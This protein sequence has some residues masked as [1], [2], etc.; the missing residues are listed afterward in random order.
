MQPPYT[1]GMHVVISYKSGIDFD[2]D[3]NIFIYMFLS[4]DEDEVIHPLG[5]QCKFVFIYLIYL[6]V[7]PLTYDKN[8]SIFQVLQSA[9]SD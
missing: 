7:V 9:F 2:F 8:S 1:L 6:I 5:N 4:R 3:C